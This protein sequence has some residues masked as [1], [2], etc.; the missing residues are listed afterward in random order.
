MR[1]AGFPTA[2][3]MVGAG[4]DMLVAGAGDDTVD[5]EGLLDGVATRWSSAATISSCGAGLWRVDADTIK[6]RRDVTRSPSGRR[7]PTA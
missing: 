6:Q 4:T 7:Q 2:A 3:T 1:P 5:G